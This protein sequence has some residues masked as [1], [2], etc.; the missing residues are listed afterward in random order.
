MWQT[1]LAYHKRHQ[2]CNFHCTWLGSKKRWFSCYNL[3]SQSEDI[4]SWFVHEGRHIARSPDHTEFG[5]R[6]LS[7]LAHLQSEGR[8]KVLVKHDRDVCCRGGFN[9]SN[10]ECGSLFWLSLHCSFGNPIGPIRY[11]ESVIK[12]F[13][14]NYDHLIQKFE[15]QS[16]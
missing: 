16:F 12:I 3:W 2:L 7:A 6:R 11:Y 8:V 9:C 10:F 15:A 4:R 5:W 13:E 1:S 14:L